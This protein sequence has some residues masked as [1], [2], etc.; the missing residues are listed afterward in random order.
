MLRFEYMPSDFHPLFLFLGEGPDLAALAKLL[1]RFAEHPRPVAVR[2]CIPGATSRD[3]LMLTPADNEFGMRDLGGSF[4]WKLTDWQAERIAERIE[5]L[6]PP[7]NKSGSEI[8]EIGSDGEI[9]VKVSRGE[10]TDDFLIS[11]R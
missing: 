9:P 10:F 3:A 6:T 1:R 11:R 5:L 2:E 4:A 8:L 7:E